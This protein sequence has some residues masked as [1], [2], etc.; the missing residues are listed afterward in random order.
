M[1]TIAAIQNAVKRPAEHFVD[2][3]LRPAVVETDAMGMPRAYGGAFAVTWRVRVGARELAVRTWRSPG[4]AG[5][6]RLERVSDFLERERPPCV[7][8]LV[9]QRRGL[10]VGE[11]TAPIAVMPWVE[12]RPL[13]EEAEHRLRD[14]DALRR[15]ADA[16]LAASAELGRLGAAHGDLHPGNIIVTPAGGVVLIDLDAM[17]VPGMEGT[18]SPEL[19]HANFSS[20]RRTAG[21]FGPHIDGFPVRLLAG[22]LRIL[23]EDPGLWDT[24]GPGNPRL[25]PDALLLRAAD[26]LA[27][28]SSPAFA[29]LAGHASPVVRETARLLGALA[30][31]PPRWAA[32]AAGSGRPAPRAVAT[33]RGWLR[34]LA[35]APTSTPTADPAADPAGT[36]TTLV[37]PTT[38]RQ[39]GSA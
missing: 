25:D 36:R 6:D 21:D 31:V 23:A 13:A 27:P 5:L 18:E 22:S 19:G 39:G 3:S 20:P 24:L 28:A 33:P 17:F 9:V 34:D 8:P 14:P 16:L 29:A 12:G 32:H 1:H 15:L 30:Q 4:A 37:W 11:V 26:L 35:S 2:P 7:V 10:R 38:P